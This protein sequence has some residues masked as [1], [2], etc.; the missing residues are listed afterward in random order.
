LRHGWRAALVPVAAIGALVFAAFALRVRPTEPTTPDVSF[1]DEFRPDLLRELLSRKAIRFTVLLGVVTEFITQGL[2]SFLPT[3]FVEYHGYSTARA[4]YLFSGFFLVLAVGGIVVGNVSDRYG[5]DGTIAGCMVFAGLGSLFLL[6]DRLWIVLVAVFLIGVGTCGVIVVQSRI[7]DYLSEDE[8][9][10]GFG[11]VRTVYMIL[12]SS[13]S[14]T[15]GFFADRFDWTVSFGFIGL[16]C[17]V[18]LVCYA[19]NW[20]FE[21][22]Y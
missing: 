11:L 8:E 15:V 3:F 21:L 2:F 7:L 22:G 18:V 13:G 6:V 10:T 1:R 4:G 14:V 19:V 9:G 20:W 16:L 5:R 17:A 12:G